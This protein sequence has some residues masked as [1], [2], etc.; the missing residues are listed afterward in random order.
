[1]T[2]EQ[3]QYLVGCAKTCK[4]VYRNTGKMPHHS[5][6]IMTNGYTLSGGHNIDVREDCTKDWD[7]F[8]QELVD[9]GIFRVARIRPNKIEYSFTSLNIVEQILSIYDVPYEQ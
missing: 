8:L 9:N 2:Q 1:M 6:I 7:N 4:R 3:I 5:K